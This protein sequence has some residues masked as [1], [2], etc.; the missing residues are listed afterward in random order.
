MRSRLFAGAIAVTTL[1]ASTL[2]LQAARPPAAQAA[3][4]SRVAYV[5]DD[6]LGAGV[7]DPN[8]PGSSIF[9][10]SVTG[11]PLANGGTY[12]GVTFTDV[13]VSAVDAAPGTAFNGF[14]TVLLYE[15]CDIGAA[16]HASTL[17]AVNAFLDDGGKVMIFDGDGCSSSGGFAAPPDYSHFLFPFTTNNPGPQGGASQ[18]YSFVEGLSTGG[19]TLTHGLDQSTPIPG[20]EIGDSNVFTGQSGAWCTSLQAKNVNNFSG[21][22]EAYARTANGGLAVWDGEDNWFTDGATSHLKQVFDLMLAQAHNPDGL[23]CAN[24]ASG[25]RLDPPTATDFMGAQQT[26]TATVVDDSSQPRAGV[27][28]SFDVLSGPDA[29]FHTTGVTDAS[30][31]ASFGY[32][33]TTAPGTD[34]IQA[35]FNDG[36]LHKSNKTTVTWQATPTNLAYTGSTTSDFDDPATLAAT[37]TNGVTNAPIS[38]APVTLQLGSQPVCTATTDAN[39]VASCG[40]TPNEPAG[41]VAVTASYAGTSITLPS[42]A[43]ATFTVT[44]EETA[45]SYTGDTKVANGTPAHLSAVLREDGTTPIAGRNVLL[46]LGSGA[47]AQSCTGVTTASGSAAC[48]IASVAQPLNSAGTLTVTAT[49]TGDA[50]Y[51]PASTSLSTVTLQYLTGRAYGLSAH[52]NLLLVQLDLPPQPDTGE[53]RTASA[54]STT[55]PCTLSISTL[56]I[57]AHSLC[58][59]VT[60]TLNPGTSVGTS[61]VQDVTIGIPGLPV[62]KA[63]AIK[64]VSTTQCATGSSGAVTIA[65]LTVG[66]LAVNANVGP[67]TGIDLGGL[68]KL[69]LNEQVPI[70]G[71]LTVN[72]L[73]VSVLGGTVDVVVASATSDAHNC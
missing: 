63:T 28:V 49:F 68:A 42:N 1:L 29:P 37:L 69:V 48:T 62:I 6:S 50:F 71:G 16:A 25:I 64:A 26:E 24:P 17:G 52:V 19:T 7:T 35:S 66:G 59:N 46:T 65:N 10:D 33:D 32:T 8:L 9:T 4:T 51:K 43:S 38:G 56:L 61:T 55:T 22:V 5:Y 70:P 47:T 18:P 40:V 45:I 14:D 13:P 58:P 31:H 12:N 73:H 11:S 20:D 53:V 30:G 54:L 34:T 44:L 27:T 57:S 21:N 15:V 36:V 3:T 2:A 72:A 41:P 60:V 67:N 39:G 23:P